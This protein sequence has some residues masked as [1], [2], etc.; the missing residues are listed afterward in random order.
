MLI[1][2][3]LDVIRHAQRLPHCFVTYPGLQLMAARYPHRYCCSNAFAL[4]TPLINSTVAIA[5]H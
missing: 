3:Q 4:L 5:R 1:A 2:Q